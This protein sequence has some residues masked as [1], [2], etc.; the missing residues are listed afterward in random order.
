MTDFRAPLRPLAKTTIV[1]LG[2][3]PVGYRCFEHLLAE[4]GSL[5]AEVIGL[6]TQPRKE[7]GGDHDLSALAAENGVPVLS[8]PGEI[9]DCDILLSV[10]YHRILTPD[11]LSKARRLAVNLHMAPLPEYRGSNQFTHAIVDEKEEFGTT[12][13]IMDARI[14]HG[15]ILAQ[16][17]WPIPAGQWV[18]DLYARTVE[19]SV[20]LFQDTLPALIAGAIAPIPQEELV[21]RYGTALHL[22]A[23]MDSLKTLDFS[24]P[25]EKFERHLRATYMPGFEPPFA[26]VEGRKVHIIPEARTA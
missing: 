3:K 4:A 2:S 22:R 19:E 21:S 17:R 12:L 6:L 20:A 25:A 18:E 16:R 7:F 14:D 11:E 13:H 24:W 9:P 23:G 26:W 15:P 1:F 8:S 10:Q 5:D